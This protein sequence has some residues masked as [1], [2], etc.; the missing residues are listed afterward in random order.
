MGAYLTSGIYKD[1]GARPLVAI[2]QRAFTLIELL[3][4]LAVLGICVVLV[5]A[6][7]APDERT[8]LQL[9][10]ERLAQLLDLAANEAR[11]TATPIIWTA[12]AGSY[13]FLRYSEETGWTEVRENAFRARVLPA[14]VTLSGVQVYNARQSGAAHLVFNPSAPPPIFSIGL[15][16]ASERCRIDG[17]AIGEVRIERGGA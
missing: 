15:A 9:E 5:A 17:S 10:A 1:K 3:V 11:L 7:A 6:R 8:Q 12:D 14:G 4:T 16:T 13:R 2:S